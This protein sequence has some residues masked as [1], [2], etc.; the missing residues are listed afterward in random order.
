MDGNLEAKQRQSFISSLNDLK[1]KVQVLLASIKAC[2]EGINLVGASRV[3]LLDVV[4]NPSVERQAISRARAYRIGQKKM[5]ITSYPN[6]SWVLHQPGNGLEA[7]GT[8]GVASKRFL[9]EEGRRSCSG[10]PFQWGFFLSFNSVVDDWCNKKQ[11]V[12]AQSKKC[13]HN[14][15]QEKS[16]TFAKLYDILSAQELYLEKMESDTNV[17]TLVATTNNVV[18]SVPNANQ[19]RSV[20]HQNRGS[21]VRGRVVGLLGA[22]PFIVGVEIVTGQGITLM[23]RSNSNSFPTVNIAQT[24][25]RT[26]RTANTS[27]PNS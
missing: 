10:Q 5:G 16:L 3:V 13:I 24:P 7:F 25:S 17:H 20:I 8:G 11:A 6:T 4:W 18:H 9:G 2:S 22:T 15:Y 23:H 1:S 12:Y 27:Y 26:T 21:E 19:Q 14:L